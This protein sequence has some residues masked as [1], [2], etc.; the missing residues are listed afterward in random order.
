MVG[1][2]ALNPSANYSLATNDFLAAGGDQYEMLKGRKV[3]AEMGTL[4]DI[5]V[6]YMN[7]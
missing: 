6:A 3:L 1:G 4:D 2:K 7:K 5:L